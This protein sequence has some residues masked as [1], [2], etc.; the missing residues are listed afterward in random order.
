MQTVLI[1]GANG[2]VGSHV[3]E[4]SQAFSDFRWIA[5]CRDATKLPATYTGER[6]IGDLRDKAYRRRRRRI[7]FHCCTSP[8]TGE[9]TAD[10]ELYQRLSAIP[11]RYSPC[12]TSRSAS[13]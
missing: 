5:A 13:D 12:W 4:A 7:E 8:P 1:T 10:L 3:L 11:V 2:F 6:R 9:P